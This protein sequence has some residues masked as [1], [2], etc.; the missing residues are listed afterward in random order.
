MAQKVVQS[1]SL[2]VAQLG[3]WIPLPP[4][5]CGGVWLFVF[6]LSRALS[7][8]GCTVHLIGRRGN[9]HGTQ[10]TIDF[11]DINLMSF[12]S[13]QILNQ[14][15]TLYASFLIE[16]KLNAL[17]SKG[18]VEVVHAHGQTQAFLSIIAKKAL[19]WKVLIIYTCHNPCMFENTSFFWGILNFF[20]NFAVKYADIVIVQT[21]S[22][23]NML[24]RKFGINKSK[25]KIIPTTSFEYQYENEKIEGKGNIVLSVGTVCPRKNQLI[26][27]KAIPRI[28][29]EIQDIQFLFIGPIGD[30]AYFKELTDFV[31][32]K[33]LVKYVVFEGEVTVDHLLQSYKTATIFVFPTL[34]E[35][36][37]VV[38]LEAMSFGLPVV[39]SNIG[40]IKDIVSLQSASALLVDPRNVYEVAN[41]IL[42]ILKDKK[43]AA[44][45]G[46]EGKK[47][48]RK[49]SLRRIAEEYCKLYESTLKSISK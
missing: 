22:T 34:A 3:S 11:H 16:A 47:L 10:L 30:Q 38:L 27:L 5:G 31:K 36:Q 9:A 42:S 20:E 2:K 33:E 21:K 48:S 44:T 35:T 14:L 43:L 15:K 6:Q 25:I 8:I 40:P 49:F 39:A 23:A 4:S 12:P 24:A 32:Q 46:A 7:K 28:I 13:T 26:L 1:K 41:T 17:I 19:R 18:E 45:I 37:G 29:A